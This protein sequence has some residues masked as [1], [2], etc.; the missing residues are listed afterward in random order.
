M[1]LAEVDPEEAASEETSVVPANQLGGK[2]HAVTPNWAKIVVKISLQKCLLFN[3]LEKKVDKAFSSIKAPEK[4]KSKASIV[5][6]SNDYM[7]IIGGEDK[8]VYQGRNYMYN[9][10]T[11]EFCERAPMVE[12]RV[13][14]GCIYFNGCIYVVGGWKE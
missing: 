7:F 14:F 12:P 2:G 10:V 6:T 5:L 8:G 11:L 4:I 1:A 13:L 3:I 9:Y